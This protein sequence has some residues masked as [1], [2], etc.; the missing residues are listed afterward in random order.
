[1][2]LFWL[3]KNSERE[4][5]VNFARTNNDSLSDVDDITRSYFGDDGIKPNRIYATGESAKYIADI[6]SYWCQINISL[7]IAFE[8]YVL[9]AKAT[10]AEHLLNKSRR[11]KIYTFTIL[12]ISVPA[13]LYLFFQLDF[14][15]QYVVV[16]IKLY[17]D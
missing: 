14:M 11:R 8:R 7:A 16:R 4:N 15:K 2:Q 13:F 3:K 9:I 17:A 5:L 10:N 6:I 1:M 12:W